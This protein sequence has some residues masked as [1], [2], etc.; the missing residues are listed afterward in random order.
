[1]LIDGTPEVE[2]LAANLD[3]NLIKVP[4]VAGLVVRSRSVV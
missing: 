3:H 2:N 1:M 4:L